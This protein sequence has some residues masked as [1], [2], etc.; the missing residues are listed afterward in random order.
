MQFTDIIF[1]VSNYKY[2][3]DTIIAIYLYYLY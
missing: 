3:H 2:I 1:N